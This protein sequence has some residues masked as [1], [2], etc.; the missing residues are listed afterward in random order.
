[1][2]RDETKR[3]RRKEKRR[4][5]E[6]KEQIKKR[7]SKKRTGENRKARPGSITRDEPNR[8]EKPIQKKEKRIDKKQKKEP[9]KSD[10]KKTDLVNSS[11]ALM[12]VG[13]LPPIRLAGNQMDSQIQQVGPKGHD[14]FWKRPFIP[15]SGDRSEC[16]KETWI[17]PP[18]KPVGADPPA[19]KGK[20]KTEKKQQLF[21]LLTGPTLAPA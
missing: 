19:K 9:R 6:R 10:K 1:L 18:G 4:E 12:A 11:Q 3:S 2:I 7:G 16:W 5:E 20:K 8:K 15:V 13:S 21:N 14:R 17:F